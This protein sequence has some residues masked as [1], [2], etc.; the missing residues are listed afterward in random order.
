M[1]WNASNDR[2][3]AKA[4][5]LCSSLASNCWLGGPLQNNVCPVLSAA[6]TV[7][8]RRCTV[9]SAAYLCT[10]STG[11]PT[12]VIKRGGLRYNFFTFPLDYS[13][14]QQYCRTFGGYLV[15]V[16]S[17]EENEVIKK[18]WNHYFLNLDPSQEV[19]YYAEDLQVVPW[20]TW[21]GA[22]DYWPCSGSPDCFDST[23]QLP[24]GYCS[25]GGLPCSPRWA[26]L[27]QLEVGGVSSPSTSVRS[28]KF[29]SG[30]L[31][32][33]SYHWGDGTSWDFQNF[34]A[35]EPS[36]T[37]N[38][39][40]TMRMDPSGVMAWDDSPCE[41]QMF[42][43]C[44]TFPE[45]PSRFYLP[46]N[47]W[48]Y[49]F[50]QSG[51]SYD[52][53]ESACRARSS[54]PATIHSDPELGA[55]SSVWSQL[56]GVNWQTW[57]GGDKLAYGGQWMWSDAS[58]MDYQSWL[59]NQ[60]DNYNGAE[61]CLSLASYNGVV[62]FNDAPCDYTMYFTCKKFVG[63]PIS[64][65]NWYGLT[66]ELYSIPQTYAS[67]TAVCEA[68]GGQLSSI[69]SQEE[70]DIVIKGWQDYFTEANPTWITWLGGDNLA[71]G[72]LGGATGYTWQ[73]GVPL[74]YQAWLPGQPDDFDPYGNKTDN[75]HCMGLWS[76][77]KEFQVGTPV[78][79][80]SDETCTKE[81][82]FTCK[83]FNLNGFTATPALTVLYNNYV[84]EFWTN[85]MPFTAAASA[86]NARGGHL[87]SIISAAE[88][89]VMVVG[90]RSYFSRFNQT[91]WQVWLGGR[92]PP[93]S[94][95]LKTDYSW[96]DGQ[97]PSGYDGWLQGQP[98]NY[99]GRELCLNLWSYEGTPGWNDFDC[100]QAQ[101]FT[102][103]IAGS[104][105]KSFVTP[106]TP[107]PTTTT[108]TTAGS[109]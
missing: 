107:T 33:N 57:L 45:F 88:Q 65:H 70:H 39:C 109:E 29:I 72:G 101:Y 17:V 75:Q 95:G 28:A 73:E 56:L 68:R 41:E 67:A 51:A 21:L 8:T 106:T 11:D 37:S 108:T 15:S 26:D 25:V 99:A 103:K 93:T 19:D 55:I 92:R 46:G 98:D 35:G 89:T 102:C 2:Q 42:F 87:A 4:K 61:H 14:A 74:D 1:D 7:T 69:H 48:R 62:G 90:W 64:I 66:Y 78:V 86:C 16:H 18:T 104:A 30:P 79:G 38:H 71:S 82:Y 85:F 32:L 10:W 5:A 58:A 59:P 60:P 40:L 80:W 12:Y 105:V 76:W 77:Q 24:A 94:Q 97:P 34:F 100:R 43:V 3:K 49:E 84:Y 53:V 63:A 22:S 9:Q 96:L 31:W 91:S 13:S 50:F 52:M 54:L 44:K 27:Q 36:N 6:G 23:T 81:Y 47:G 83:T 20:R